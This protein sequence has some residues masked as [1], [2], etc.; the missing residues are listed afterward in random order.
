MKGQHSTGQQFQCCK[1]ARVNAE[2]VAGGS[3]HEKGRVKGNFGVLN[4]EGL[5]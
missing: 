5:S 3:M 1:S 4:F 2:R